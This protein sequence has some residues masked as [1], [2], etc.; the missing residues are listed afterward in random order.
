M[1][2]ACGLF[3]LQRAMNI[4]MV[5][6][7]Q[8]KLTSPLLPQEIK[9]SRTIQLE[10]GKIK[11]QWLCSWSIGK[12]VFSWHCHSF[13]FIIIGSHFV[14][15]VFSKSYQ[16]Y[17]YFGFF[18]FNVE[19]SPLN[20]ATGSLLVNIILNTCQKFLLNKNPVSFKSPSS[21]DNFW[22][23]FWHQLCRIIFRRWNVLHWKVIVQGDW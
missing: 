10:D 12:E 1:L 20:N 17:L 15:Q 21:L 6:S 19:P 16:G 5:L 14:Y 3:T 18:Q 13:L 9:W 11:T 22:T 7:E 23:K 8:F 4:V 2:T